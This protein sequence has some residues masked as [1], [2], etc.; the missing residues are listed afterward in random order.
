MMH[1]LHL[2]ELPGTGLPGHV[3]GDDPI[4]GTNRSRG[5]ACGG[6]AEAEPDLRRRAARTLVQARRGEVPASLLNPEVFKA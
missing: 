4:Q 1:L 2:Q 3:G 6:I 5:L